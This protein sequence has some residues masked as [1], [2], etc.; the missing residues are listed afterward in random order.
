MP[1]AR[2]NRAGAKRE[3][4]EAG[5]LGDGA[6]RGDNE[7]GLGSGHRLPAEPGDVNKASESGLGRREEPSAPASIFS[8]GPT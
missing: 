8:L 7:G 4:G 2:T 3:R 5:D 1:T 6:G